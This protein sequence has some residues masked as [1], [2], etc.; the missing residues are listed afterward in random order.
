MRLIRFNGFNEFLPFLFLFI[1]LYGILSV[2]LKSAY[3]LNTTIETYVVVSKNNSAALQSLAIKKALR[4]SLRK[5]VKKLVRKKLSL[6][7]NSKN[8]K[9]LNKNIYSNGMKYI[10]SFKVI[11]AKSY[12][13][14]YYIK[15]NVLIR[16][17]E[18]RNKLKSLGFKVV[19]NVLISKRVKYH[20]Y[21][22]KFIGRYQYAD[23][24]KLQKLMIK[25]SKHL[26]NLY[27]SS[28]SNNFV[29]I[30]VLYYGSIIRLFK[31]VKD[32]V[33]T[34]LNAKV[35]PIKGNIIIVNVK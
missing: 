20:V 1:F 12:L 8:Y 11:K 13:N 17:K 14:L 26:N 25:Y 33:K 7:K 4:L 5:A 21:Y 6:K 22:I 24:N 28:F 19:K 32:I 23:P 34:Y 31:K 9:I 30:K 35:S 10:Y 3:G 15:M 2:F 29:E 16:E 18:L 27:V